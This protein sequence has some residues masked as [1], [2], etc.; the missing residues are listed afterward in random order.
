LK[1][2]ALADL[3]DALDLYRY[4]QGQAGTADSSARMCACLAKYF[5]HQVR[6]AVHHLWVI[7]E[8]QRGIHKPAQFHDAL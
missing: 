3:K 4:P 6:R 5:G 7:S 8:I 1:E 2:Q